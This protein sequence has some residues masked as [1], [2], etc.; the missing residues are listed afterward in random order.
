MRIVFAIASA[1]AALIGG[2][3]GTPN[4]ALESWADLDH[5]WGVAGDVVYST[6][7]GRTWRPIFYG[8]NQV[9]RVER[10]STGAGIVLTGNSKMTAFWTRD[11]GR[12]WYPTGAQ[13]SNAV[14]H[15]GQ[16]FSSAG[17]SLQQLQ[18]W[19]PRGPIRCRG[20]WWAT[21]FGPGTNPRL[22]KTVC[23]TTPGIPVR[24]RKVFTLSH[25]GEFAP[26][27]LVPVPGGVA[28]VSVD[29]TPHQRPLAVVVYQNGLAAEV[30]LPDPAPS[31]AGFSDLRLEVSWPRLTLYAD[32]DT[33]R[34][35]WSSVDG[36]AT[37]SVLG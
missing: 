9:Y 15:G 13:I 20:T 22:S 31:D 5:G 32:A 29:A 19:P 8:G 23:S 34:M 2:S 17:A 24:T 18:P 26:D 27:T 21:A 12:H 7:N 30:E 33:T 25:D 10:T 14:G 37:W 16:L 35:V 36:G 3:P 28:G 11:N 6:E 4:F 1:A